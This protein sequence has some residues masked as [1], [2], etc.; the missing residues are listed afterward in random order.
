MKTFIKLIVICILLYFQSDLHAIEEI[1]GVVKSVSDSAVIVEI[2][3]YN[4]PNIG[5]RVEISDEIPDLGKVALSGTWEVSKAEANSVSVIGKGSDLG[6]PQPGYSVMIYSTNEIKDID[7]K[8]SHDFYTPPVDNRIIYNDTQS[9][10]PLHSNANG[11]I[12]KIWTDFDVF[13]NGKKGMLIHTKFNIKKCENIQCSFNI[14]FF[15]KLKNP[16]KDF[17]KRYANEAGN[18]AIYQTF[19]PMY[20]DVIFDDFQTFIPYDE[21]HLSGGKHD[22]IFIV[23]I[24]DS[25]NQNYI[26]NSEGTSFYYESPDI[27]TFKYKGNIQ[28]IWIDHNIIQNRRKGMLIH[29]KFNAQKLR[30]VKCALNIYF[31]DKQGN[32]LKDFNKSYHTTNGNVSVHENFVPQYDDT[33]FNDFKLFMPV[34]ELHMT[35]GKHKLMFIAKLYNYDDKK[36]FAE[37]K[38]IYIN[39]G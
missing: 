36:I 7:V 26:I 20:A 37:S 32:P 25:N 21:L 10:V 31:Y 14:E 9:N 39:I 12:H 38:K 19:M 24:S 30:G 3:S 28:E 29:T 18:I 1:A 22:L 16:L 2:N 11:S 33:T 23:K 6:T 17:N 15:N 34:Q 8:G 4:G 27:D 35:K 5:D 13:K